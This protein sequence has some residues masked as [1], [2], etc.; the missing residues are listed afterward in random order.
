MWT[1]DQWFFSVHSLEW[2]T[3][4]RL[5]SVFNFMGQH[6]YGW[7]EDV[8]GRDSDHALRNLI[9]SSLPV[10]PD[11]SQLTFCTISYSHYLCR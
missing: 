2:L 8:S 7:L 11:A 3:D 9:A 5:S 1:P 4:R 6:A 10:G